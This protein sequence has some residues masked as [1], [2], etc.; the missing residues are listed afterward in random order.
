[1]AKVHR[2]RK[3]NKRKKTVI[4]QWLLYALLR[5]MLFVIF[6]FKVETILKFAC[7][8]G[9]ALWKHYP[10]GRHRAIDN[11]K[12][13]YPEKDD[14]WIKHTGRRSF[15][16]LV[17]LVVDILF[18][19]RLIDRDNWQ[20]YSVYKNIER[21]KWLMLEGRPLI[22]IAAHYSNFEIMGYLLSV[23]GFN[24]YSVARPLDNKFINKYLYS[25]RQKRGQKI[26]DKKGASEQMQQ[27]VESG[28]TLCFVADQDA[29]KK[30]V[31][32]DFFGRK[33]SSYKSIGLLAIQYN[34]PIVVGV[35]RRVG[36]RFFFEIEVA[37][38]IF[39]DEWAD[40]DDPLTWV[41][42]EYT[43]AF[44][45]AVR[46]DPTQYWWIHRRWKTRPKEERKQSKK[47]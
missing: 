21:T 31:F 37:R 7:F 26:I 6:L 41:T 43:K 2:K 25:I 15:E 17:M 11:L 5:V 1:M 10:R 33:A 30:G 18:T 40:K 27:I 4:E 35:S 42:A 3:R 47:H 12:A 45:Q 20:R 13:A 46:D 19:P 29:G 24:I 36:N 22:M 44:E 32:V 38:M 8:L 34:I 28:G 14:R 39:P 16:Q 9:R 23:F